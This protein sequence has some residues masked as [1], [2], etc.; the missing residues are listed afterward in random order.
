VTIFF[1]KFHGELRRSPYLILNCDETHVSSRKQ[2]KVLGVGS[3]R[4]LKQCREKLPH[5]T[6]MCTVTGAGDRF[7]PMFILPELVKLPAEL[8]DLTHRAYFASTGTGW[9]TQRTFL[10]Y[11][12]ILLYQLKL[13]RRQI[14]SEAVDKRFL[15]ILDGHTSRWTY[16]AIYILHIGGVD[17]LVLPAHCT[18]VLQ[19]FDVSIAGVLKMFLAEF[20]E[21]L[22]ITQDELNILILNSEIPEGMEDKRRHLLEAFLRAWERAAN[23]DNIR[24]GFAKCGIWPVKPEI[25]LAN[26]YT[27]KLNHGELF[28]TPGEK[29][30]DMNCAMVTQADRLEILKAKPNHLFTRHER[31]L[32]EATEQWRELLGDPVASGRYLGGHSQ[33][34]LSEQE[35]WTGLQIPACKRY[36]CQVRKVHQDVVWQLACRV[37]R[38]LPILIAVP[39]AAEGRK[40]SQ[41]LTDQSVEHIIMDGTLSP[42]ERHENWYD[43]QTGKANICVGTNVA[44]RGITFARRIMTVHPRIPDPKMFL[45]TSPS[46]SLIFFR[47]NG[48]LSPLQDVGVTFTFLARSQYDPMEAL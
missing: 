39:N 12:H 17:V 35:P 47:E 20:C 38:T 48:D 6:A 36:A 33:F 46:H 11:A 1:D 29:L 23:E 40:F 27:R 2:F 22:T 25:P 44:L 31:K 4:A 5:V 43:F 24:A 7:P 8:Q 42:D 18:H 19:V 15:L 28:A 45:M 26:H 16:E 3:Q 21:R 14:P 41:Y 30:T 37:A 9:M 10:M 13:Y 32:V 34:N